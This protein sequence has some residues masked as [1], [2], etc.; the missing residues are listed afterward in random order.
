MERNPYFY[1]HNNSI[2]NEIYYMLKEIITR[3]NADGLLLSGGLDSSIIA[4]FQKPKYT[5]TVSLEGYGSDQN[6]AKL[7]AEK[8]GSKHIQ[9]IIEKNK[10]LKIEEKIVNLFKTFDPIFIRNSSVIFAAVEKAREINISSIL[11]GDG[12]DELFAGY[13]YL[14]RYYNSKEEL[15]LTLKKLWESMHFP[16]QK[17]GNFFN[18]RVFSPYLD[19]NFL[20]FA[21]SIN[22]SMKIGYYQNK[23]WG[24]FILRKCFENWEHLEQIA[25]REKE[26]QEEG[27]GFSNIRN[28]FDQIISDNEY[29]N[30]IF[31]I[32]NH[33][34]VIIRNKEHLFYYLLYRKYFSSPKDDITINDKRICPHCNCSFI[35]NGHF[36][37]VC[38]AFPVNPIIHDN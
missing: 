38:G 12:S 8:Y 27:S 29:S 32:S 9:V 30:H 35:W 1:N 16:S 11:T 2:C 17:I 37:R 26:A 14:K 20:T 10:L 18:V 7:I 3:E 23:I 6:Y 28:Y 34:N 15:E 36:C 24:K 13:N 5:F 4:S 33:D 25:W 22:V 19:E 31:T 21:K